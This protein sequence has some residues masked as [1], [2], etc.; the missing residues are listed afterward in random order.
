MQLLT[1]DQVEFWHN[2][3]KTGWMHSQ[4]EHIK[5]WRK[6]WFV[7]K[8]ASSCAHD[9]QRAAPPLRDST[10]PHTHT[11]T[12]CPIGVYVG[13]LKQRG[14]LL[15]GFLFRFANSEVGPSTKP[16]GIVD[17]STVTDVADGSAATSRPNSIKLTT[18]TG[19]ICYLCES[20]TSQARTL[21][22]FCV[23][24]F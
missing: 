4:G 11:Y 1:A 17:L 9:L 20:E 24:S 18:A 8:Q 15:Q 22:I 23:H 19:Q 7:L 2:P 16:R 14:C 10:P 21:D 5:T 13:L 6:R 12:P 3:E